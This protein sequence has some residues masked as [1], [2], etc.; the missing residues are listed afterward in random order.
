MSSTIFTPIFLEKTG[1]YSK[2][3]STMQTIDILSITK[4]CQSKTSILRYVL[5][6][7]VNRKNPTLGIHFEMNNLIHF[8]F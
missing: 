1:Y 6:F 5:H 2:Y 4:I 3:I 8:I 7:P